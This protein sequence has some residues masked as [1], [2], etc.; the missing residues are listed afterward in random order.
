MEK[1]KSG[2]MR[3]AKWKAHL[4]LFVY[5]RF[6]FHCRETT[7]FVYATTYSAVCAVNAEIVLK[8]GFLPFVK[9]AHFLTTGYV[10]VPAVHE[11]IWSPRLETRISYSNAAA[12]WA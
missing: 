6:S 12:A 1:T 3:A 10:S 7:S 9:D 4:E 8:E 11:I 5:E 2:L